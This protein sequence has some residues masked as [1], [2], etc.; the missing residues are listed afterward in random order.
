MHRFMAKV[1]M[2]FPTQEENE[3]RAWRKRSDQESTQ[4]PPC[5]VYGN[6]VFM[7]LSNILA[8]AC[9]PHLHT[10]LELRPTFLQLQKQL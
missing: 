10:E 9:W 5:I 1:T 4:D 2:S 6:K 3:D 7:D 8:N